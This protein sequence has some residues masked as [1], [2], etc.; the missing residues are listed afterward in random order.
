MELKPVPAPILNATPTPVT[1]T[2]N[3]GP[4]GTLP[5]PT[6]VLMKYEVTKDGQGVSTGAAHNLNDV[7]H[8]SI[9]LTYDG[10]ADDI[11]VHDP[12]PDGASY[13]DDPTY[14]T[15]PT[16][17]LVISGNDIS[18]DLGSTSSPIDQVFRLSLK[19]TK[20]NVYINNQATVDIT[21]GQAI[22]DTGPQDPPNPH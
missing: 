22:G 9:H 5:V 8:Y 19:A 11:V 18:W 7:I 17:G 1:G 4:G 14:P 12:I 6:P 10:T 15:T 2:G 16:T 21:N 13:E 3:P 20:N